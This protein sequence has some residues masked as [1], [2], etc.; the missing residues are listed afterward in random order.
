MDDSDGKSNM[1]SSYF[2]LVQG[3]KIFADIME[4][5]LQVT[6]KRQSPSHLD[7]VGEFLKLLS[8]PKYNKFDSLLQPYAYT[9]LIKP[10]FCTIGDGYT[11]NP[12]IF[13]PKNV[14]VR[15]S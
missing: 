11:V 3:G 7:K 8:S 5:S 10:K 1:H 15:N 6:L 4:L 13:V 12:K 9:S 2:L 14:H